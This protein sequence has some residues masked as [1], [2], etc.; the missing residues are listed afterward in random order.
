VAPDPQGWY[1]IRDPSDLV[2]PYWLLN[3][4][5]RRYPN[6]RYR[7]RIQLGDSS[8][9]VV[10]ESGDVVFVVDNSK[11]S[12]SFTQMRWREAGDS[13]W[14]E[15]PA[16]CPVIRRSEGATVELEVSYTASARHFRD[17]KVDMIGCGANDPVR[18]APVDR[19]DYEHWHTSPSDNSYSATEVFELP[20]S[21]PEGSYTARLFANG[22]AFNP[23]GYDAGPGSDWHYDRVYSWSH[24]RR[25]IS[26]VRE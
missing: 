4:N 25:A 13:S 21:L 6:G 8:K 2:F 11:P 17:V 24:P 18:K 9:S 14:T 3:W 20:G 7:V 5:T 22:R 19:A 26:L 16:V 15:L 12:A 23:A 1:E 10:D